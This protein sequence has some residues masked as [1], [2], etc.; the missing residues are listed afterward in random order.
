M[1]AGATEKHLLDWITSVELSC[2]TAG[3]PSLENNLGVLQDQNLILKDFE[4]TSKPH[5]E[6]IQPTGEIKYTYRIPRL[7]R[8]RRSSSGMSEQGR[9]SIGQD[10]PQGRGRGR[11]MLKR[12]QLSYK[13]GPI[14]FEDDEIYADFRPP[15]P[16]ESV[17][18]VATSTEEKTTN[19]S[20]SSSPTKVNLKLARALLSQSDPPIYFLGYGNNEEEEDEPD[21]WV[22]QGMKDLLCHL[23]DKMDPFE[24]ICSCVKAGSRGIFVNGWAECSS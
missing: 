17:S 24:S 23:Q 11:D 1:A 3:Y 5:S 21:N 13:A 9:A 7:K 20:R 15:Q 4:T 6:P 2:A 10:A 19:R 22:P 16:H 18:Q 14:N 12:P 8:K